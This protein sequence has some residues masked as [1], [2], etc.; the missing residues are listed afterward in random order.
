MRRARGFTVI[1]LAVTL[2]IITILAAVAWSLSEAGLRNANLSSGSYDLALRLSGLRATAMSEGTD[3]VFVLVDAPSN[4]GTTCNASPAQCVTVWI[5]KS[6]N[7]SWSLS[8]FNPGTPGANANVVDFV[9]MPRGVHFELGAATPPPVPFNSVPVFDAQMRAS[10]GGRTCIAIRF[11]ATGLVSGEKASA[12][13]TPNSVG[14]AFVLGTDLNALTRAADR[15]GVMVSFPTAI[16]RSY[17][18]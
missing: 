8:S 14:A 15:R 17:A 9:T 18:Y 4:N 16:V 2:A 6:P 13:A 12:G 7:S 3:Y 10:C 5:L 11:G 1:E